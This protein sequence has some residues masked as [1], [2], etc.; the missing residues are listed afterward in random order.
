MEFN[1]N[2][3]ITAISTITASVF[4]GLLGYVMNRNSKAL[5]AS[6]ERIAVL[7]SQHKAALEQVEAYHVEE[8]LL[9]AELAK[10]G[11]G[12]IKTH[13]TRF[14]DMVSRQGFARPSM[15]A[16]DARKA[17]DELKAHSVR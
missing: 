9:V 1:P 2:N 13:K 7:A 12:G 3:I 17:I 8:G 5:A 14:R 10:L 11:R 6:R 15:T 16:L 4:S